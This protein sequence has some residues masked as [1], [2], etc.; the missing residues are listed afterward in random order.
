MLG[1]MVLG[2]LWIVIFYVT[3]GTSR[4]P[5]PAL[6][7]WNLAVGFLLIMIWFVMTTRWR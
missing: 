3:A 7:N 1:F 2:L 5:I 4:L 6:S